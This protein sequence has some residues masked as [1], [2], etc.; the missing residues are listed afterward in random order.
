V[1]SRNSKPSKAKGIEAD[2]TRHPLLTALSFLGLFVVWLAVTGFEGL[3]KPWVAPLFM[4]SPGAVL[5]TFVRLQSDG[6][7]GF[8]LL[9]HL[10]TSLGRFAIAM[11]FSVVVGIALGIGM[12]MSNA[13]RAVLDGPM[14]T[15]RPVPKLA[16]LPL[17]IVWFGIGELSKFVV[18]AS[19]LLPIMSISAMQGV[20]QVNRRKLLAAYSLGASEWTVFCRVLIPSALPTI[21][22]GLRVCMGL[23][24][25]MLVGA[26]LIA[27]NRGIAFMAISASDF[28]QTDVVFVGVITM[29][30][31]G[32][33]LDLV[34]RQIERRVV[35]WSGRE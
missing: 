26:E 10:M 31:V 5:G 2:V 35:H 33:G 20:M 23:G 16:L 11:T 30:A 12:G 24:I 6:Y 21:F 7:Q 25:T 15:T 8:S 4:P 1:I 29:A 32:Y 13:F 28:L 9:Q 22:V 14:E 19:A 34:I 27:T 18:I 3:Y 17:F